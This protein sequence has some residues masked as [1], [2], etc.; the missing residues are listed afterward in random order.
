M[1]HRQVLSK[2]FLTLKVL[3]LNKEDERRKDQM[4][5]KSLMHVKKI[6]FRINIEHKA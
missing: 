5:H 2:Y 4:K 3:Q 6:N 1:C